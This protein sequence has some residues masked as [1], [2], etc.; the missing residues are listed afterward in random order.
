MYA[1]SSF[2]FIFIFYF[3][4]QPLS[5]QGTQRE[6]ETDR[7]TDRQTEWERGE[8]DR[9]RERETERQRQ[10]DRDRQSEREGR[11]RDMYIIISWRKVEFGTCARNCMHRS[12]LIH[13][14]STRCTGISPV[15]C[16]LSFCT[17]INWR[18][19][20][21]TTRPIEET[22]CTEALCL[23][24]QCVRLIDGFDTKHTHT[25]TVQTRPIPDTV[26]AGNCNLTCP[27][28]T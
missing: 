10:K 9:D 7:Q 14:T 27:Q 28:Q 6:R 15:R 26:G 18:T 21:G 1:S 5:K 24:C 22:L 17:A 4:I 2:F 16:S 19:N 20:I 23:N 8:T 11:Q 25:Y 3:Y 13:T 12:Q